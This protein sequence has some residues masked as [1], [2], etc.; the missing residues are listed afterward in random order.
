MSD[1]QHKTTVDATPEAI[2]HALCVLAQACIDEGYDRM[3]WTLRDGPHDPDGGV[4]DW[5]IEVAPAKDAA[6]AR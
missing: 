6:D 3:V 5:R 4:T 2:R 1:D